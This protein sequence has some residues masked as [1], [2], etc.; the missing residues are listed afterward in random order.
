MKRVILV[1]SLLIFLIA[2][3]TWMLFFPHTMIWAE[4]VSFFS[5]APDFTELQ[6][7]LPKNIFFY[8]GAF[9]LQFFSSPVAGAFI[10]AFMIWIIAMS[11]DVAIYRLT[12]KPRLTWFSMIPAS[13]GLA[14]MP[15]YLTLAVPVLWCFVSLGIALVS[16]LLGYIPFFRRLRVGKKAGWVTYA[17]LPAL[18]LA[19]AALYSVNRKMSRTNERI[20]RI[21]H[22]AEAGDWY[23]VIEEITPQEAAMD[24][25][26]KR[27]AMFALMATG[28]LP[29]RMLEYGMRSPDDMM[30]TGSKMR[31]PK[32]IDAF[33]YE[34]LGA[35]N[36]VIRKMFENNPLSPFGFSNRCMRRITDAFIRQGNTA[37]AEKYLSVME[38]SPFKKKWVDS[39]REQL[40]L[41]EKRGRRR[42]PNDGK[43]LVGTISEALVLE[44]SYR[45][46]LAD[47]TDRRKLDVFLCGVL[48]TK[49]IDQFVR[50][51]GTEGKNIY[52]YG[53]K[54]PRMYQE[55]LMLASE[56]TDSVKALFVPEGGVERDFRE[57]TRLRDR[58]DSFGMTS[59]F[60]NSYWTY[61]YLR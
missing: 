51:F 42:N 17:L 38:T 4:S 8:C 36:E 25:V 16:F 2:M 35:D 7:E 19:L 34:I 47:S 54:L 58:Q 60:R 59:K 13:V 57:F 41:S 14:V 23:G 20:Y 28:T 5:F 46:L 53:K 9:L 1:Q 18:M 33:F 12:K 24:P 27:F 26:M 56:K 11:F 37:L 55:A 40:R 6:M 50:T 43:T 39:R 61:Y 31:E 3:M 44:D 30:F 22:L 29:D 10:I 45:L 48:A 21:E 15:K 52:S 32:Y 49:D